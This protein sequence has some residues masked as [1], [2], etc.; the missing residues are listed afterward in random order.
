MPSFSSTKEFVDTTQPFEAWAGHSLNGSDDGSFSVLLPRSAVRAGPH[1]VGSVR[2]HSALS[3]PLTEG[4]WLHF[5]NYIAMH[6]H[7]DLFTSLDAHSMR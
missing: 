7:L 5:E 1:I 2:G 6:E 4:L 3:G